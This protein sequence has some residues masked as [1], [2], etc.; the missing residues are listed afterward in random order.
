MQV[1]D[2]K[3]EA[4]QILNAK[5][6][7]PIAVILHDLG[8]SKGRLIVECWGSAWATYWGAMGGKTLRE[9]IVSCDADYI[10]N[11]MWCQQHKRTKT[12]DAYLR[13]VIEAVQ[14]ALRDPSG[15]TGGDSK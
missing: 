10:Q 1:I 6:L 13:R 5:A 7:D 9:F 11:R 8:D 3:F 14:E 15:K 4:F 12:N 2:I